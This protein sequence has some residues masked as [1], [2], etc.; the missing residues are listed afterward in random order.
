MLI[1]CLAACAHLTITVSKIERDIYEKIVILSYPLHSTPLLGGFPSEYR[2][3]F[4]CGKTRMV[5][6]P[7]GEKN[8]ED[9]FIRFGATPERYRQTD[10]RTPGDGNSR[11]IHS[12]IHIRLMYKLT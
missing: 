2:H 11:A 4:W 10:G 9:I 6:L 8:L 1:D 12:F 7:D 5:T 3:P